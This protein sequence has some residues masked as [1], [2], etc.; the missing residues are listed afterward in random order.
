M[1]PPIHEP[2]GSHHDTARERRALRSAATAI[3]A[4]FWRAL[5]AE[6]AWLVLASSAGGSS[7]PC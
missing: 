1:H 6:V 7:R 3:R 5:A 2:T 4:L